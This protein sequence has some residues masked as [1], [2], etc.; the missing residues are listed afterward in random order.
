MSQIVWSVHPP[1]SQKQLPAT[2]TS[3]KNNS[4]INNTGNQTPSNPRPYNQFVQ[5]GS[6]SQP[7]QQFLK[8]S[9]HQQESRM[10]TDSQLPAHG[11]FQAPLPDTNKLLSE[12]QELK[13]ERE[14]F[15]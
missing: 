15:F 6:P 5:Y 9:Q 12:L 2:G 13:E 11:E 8:E 3:R 14:S 10:Q 1:K 7:R 4:Q